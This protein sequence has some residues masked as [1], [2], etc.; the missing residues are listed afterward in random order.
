MVKECLIFN[1]NNP[2]AICAIDL[3]G[4]EFLAPAIDFFDAYK[5]TFD[6]NIYRT[7]HAG[8]FYINLYFFFMVFFFKINSYTR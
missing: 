8:F 3:C 4:A 6:K 5:L 1:E 2:G 7:V